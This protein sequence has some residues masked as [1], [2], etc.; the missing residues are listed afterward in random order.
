MT[1][2]LILVVV[3]LCALAFFL[4][5]AVRGRGLAINNITE[6]QGKTQPVDLLAFRNLTSPRE[7]HYLREHLPAREFRS[8]QR[9]RLLAAMAYLNC[10]SENAAVLLCLGEAARRSPN[11]QI[12]EAGLLL[13]NN[14][15]R[16][17]LY[18]MSARTGF[19]VAF[20][21]P[22][23]R[24]S[25]AAVSDLYQELA[26]TA[27]RLGYLQTGLAAHRTAAIL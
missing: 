15:L 13:V 7:E 24:L 12:A 20:L 2:A 27:S 22:G 23:L 8:V 10:V 26:G 14:A 19:Y 17:R 1:V 4:F 9:E 18:A 11:P 5:L 16:V 3:A 21:F 6:L 25:P